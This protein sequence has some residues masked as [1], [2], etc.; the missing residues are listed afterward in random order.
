MNTTHTKEPLEDFETFFRRFCNSYQGDN[1]KDPMNILWIDIRDDHVVHVF[2][3]FKEY[4]DSALQSRDREIV[5]IIENL[6]KESE[7][8]VPF[9]KIHYQSALSDLKERIQNHV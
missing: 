8:Y 3:A 9:Q 2:K 4:L 7:K 5:D 1:E 6:E